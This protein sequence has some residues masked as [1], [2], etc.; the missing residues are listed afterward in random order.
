MMKSE[1][2]K[3]EVTWDTLARRELE[4]SGTLRERIEFVNTYDHYF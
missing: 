4:L 3:E 1:Y 2:P